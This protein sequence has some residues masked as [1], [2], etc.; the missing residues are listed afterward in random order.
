[1]FRDR[2]IEL[3]A[4]AMLKSLDE[5]EQAEFVKKYKNHYSAVRF[6]EVSSFIRNLHN[7]E[8][9]KFLGKDC[10]KCKTRTFFTEKYLF[11]EIDVQ[12]DSCLNHECYVQ[13]W[14]K[15][16]ET[17]IKS[18]KG[19][20]RSHAAAAMIAFDY[21]V[22]LDKI[23]G[24]SVT[25]GEVHCKIIEKDWW[26]VVD[27]G[28]AGT[29]PCFVVS[30]DGDKL[31]VKPAYWKEGKEGTTNLKDFSAELKLLD[32]P[33]DEDA[34]VRE[35][36]K[37]KNVSH[38]GFTEKVRQKVLDR[39]IAYR[40]GSK[41]PPQNDAALLFR[42]VFQYP[43][44]KR[45][46]IYRMVTGQDYDEKNPGLMPNDRTVLTLLCALSFSAYDL[47]PVYSNKETSK[48]FDW[49]GMPPDEIKEL[50]RE[51]IRAQLPKPKA[52]K[53]AAPVKKGKKQ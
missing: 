6:H 52:G 3:P 37:A 8:V 22:N 49:S 28:G 31:Q 33:E 17:R 25:L 41:D 50:Y 43:S 1:M 34:A 27:K 47:P 21:S 42:D 12:R 11:P 15:L 7:D 32:L 18:L 24:K 14:T 38:Y 48:V 44:K 20:H 23:L 19:E 40:A 30:V 35:A 16:L 10:G 45:Q 46:E 13:K 26:A 9:Y 36:L 39:L 51:V 4:A 29:A 5:K 2:Q 53:D